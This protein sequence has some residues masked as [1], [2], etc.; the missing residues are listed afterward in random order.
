MTKQRLLILETIRENDR[1]M[2]AEEIYMEIRKK[3]PTIARATVYNN[4]KRLTCE[5]KIR[6]LQVVGEP[7]RYDRNM[8]FHEHLICEHCGEMTDAWPGEWKE[9]M[10]KRLGIT[11]TRY[12]LT[13]YHICDACQV[14][15]EKV[16]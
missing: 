1:H 2:T 4:L 11:I 10:E 16:K 13:M 9:E 3:L 12:H 8:V 7:D 5:G 6:K 15:M 14:K